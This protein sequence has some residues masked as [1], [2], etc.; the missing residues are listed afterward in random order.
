MNIYNS[1]MLIG[2]NACLYRQEPYSVF[3]FSYKAEMRMVLSQLSYRRSKN[4]NNAA[5][6]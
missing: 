2:K 5:K 1:F 4:K 3:F 6:C